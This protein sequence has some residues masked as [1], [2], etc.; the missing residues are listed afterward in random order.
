MHIVHVCRDHDFKD[1]KLFFRFM[2]DTRDKGHVRVP[3]DGTE[4]LSWKLF[5]QDES[6][7]NRDIA[8]AELRLML[9]GISE[10]AD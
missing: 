5:L 8:P 1:K 3:E 10:M 6:K 4:P 9:D 2:S 7:A